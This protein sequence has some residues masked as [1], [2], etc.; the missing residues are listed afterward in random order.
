M[1]KM[2]Q[3]TK[4]LNNKIQLLPKVQA[5]LSE[6][7]TN[8]ELQQLKNNNP[9]LPIVITIEREYVPMYI[10][11]YYFRKLF[12]ATSI[13]QVKKILRDCK[14]PEYIIERLVGDVEI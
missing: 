6:W 1:Q 11:E 8:W 7:W 2:T 13:A 9:H 3:K 5:F 14:V 10:R 4:G 12:K